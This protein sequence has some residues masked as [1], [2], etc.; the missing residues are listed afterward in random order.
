MTPEG[1]LQF[2]GVS[3]IGMGRGRSWGSQSFKGCLLLPGILETGIV[4]QAEH[5]PGPHFTWAGVPLIKK[6]AQA[7]L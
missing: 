1:A 4:S 6:E 2:E 7:V 3:F 5:W